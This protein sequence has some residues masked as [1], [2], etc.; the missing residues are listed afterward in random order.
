MLGL[1]VFLLM[2]GAAFL[3]ALLAVSF[4]WASVEVRA[5]RGGAQAV[6]EIDG[7]SDPNGLI[8]GEHFSTIRVWALL[9][10]RISHVETMRQR[11][12]EAGLRWPVGR[13]TL[14]MLLVASVSALAL[15]QADF[16]PPLVVVI[17]GLLTGMVP[18]LC[19]LALRRRRFAAFAAQFPEALDSLTRA[20]K[21]GYPL[22]G[23][24]ELLAM[25]QPEPLATEMRRIRDEW[26]LGVGWDQA[27]DHLADRIPVAEVRMFV[28]AVKLQNRIG[29]RLNDV[30]ARLGETMRD[31]AALESEVRAVSAHSRLTGTVLTILPIA[32]GILMFT[33][34]RDYMMALVRA[35]EGRA[36]LW[37]AAAANLVAHFL[38]RRIARVRI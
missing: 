23:A 3:T 28:A 6:L 16:L 9:L 26:K 17:A 20:L 21:A 29:G 34:N 10:E 32:I 36:V 33:I 27:L 19:V 7:R 4:Y 14:G 5:R 24:V 31:N 22:A 12:A 1:L 37:G 13:L 15:Y 8:R 38:I 25:E 30:L 35:P 2:F 18:Y 11:V